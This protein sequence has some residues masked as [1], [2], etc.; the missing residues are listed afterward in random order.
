MYSKYQAIAARLQRDIDANVYVDRL[1]SERA[2]TRKYGT[3]ITTLRRA[4]SVLVDKGLL[5]KRQPQGTFITRPERRVIRVSMLTSL[6][7]EAARQEMLDNFSGAFPDVDI[8]F[9]L[10]S[11]RQVAVSECDLVGIGHLAP[12]SCQELAVPFRRLD[13]E[14]LPFD[15]YFEPAFDVYR[16]DD[17]QYALPVLFSPILLLG[18]SDLLRVAGLGE[19]P[20]CLNLRVMLK[21]AR[22]AR[23][24]GVALWSQSTVV[25]LVRSLVFAAAVET[26]VVHSIDPERLLP[27][28]KAWAPLLSGDLVA[29]ADDGLW[30]S[31]RILF[32]WCARQS[33][34]M[35]DPGRNRL[36]FIPIEMRSATGVGGEF[37]L[38]NRRSGQ[39][40]LA[41]RVALHFLSPAIQS[42]LG[43]NGVGLPVLKSAATDC[44][45]STPWRDDLFIIGVKNICANSAR[46]HDFLHRLMLKSKSLTSGELSAA[47]FGRWLGD[48]IELAGSLDESRKSF[49]CNAAA[50]IK[51]DGIGGAA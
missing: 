49:L 14:G 44:L 47:F 43:R 38:V 16:L 36:L 20:D 40:G 34:Y 1:P 9:H 29:E 23:E 15:A 32:R 10:R 2:L 51:L 31:K 6:L 26:G 48:E 25:R 27:A 41:R 19:E 18:N 3:T 39:Q 22:F 37:L 5:V 45:G 8:Q 35:H 7:S 28:L 12:V 4:Q 42:I 24:R 21:V 33:L 30:E 11:D 17:L 46:E 13:L 50:D